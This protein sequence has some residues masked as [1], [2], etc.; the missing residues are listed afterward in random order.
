MKTLLLTLLLAV[1]I[2]ACND[3]ALPTLAPTDDALKTALRGVWLPTQ[4]QIKYQI[5]LTP[6]QRDTTVTL[7][8][9]TAP[10]LVPGRANV[11]MPFTDTLYIGTVATA[12]IDTFFTRNRGSRQQGNFFLVS[13]A[14][15]GATVL[16]IGRPTYTRG[17]LTRWNY[18]F[19][20]HGTVL[21]NAQNQP[22]FTYTSY[23]NY[24]L[25]VQSVSGN[26]LVL[27]FQTTGN[28]NNLPQVPITP[29]NQSLNTT[30]GGRVALITATF[31]K[32]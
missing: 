24:P 29:A 19:V 16:R 31:T 13:G 6:R 11:I 3:D 18:D 25:T 12:R 26:R 2:M 9:T 30:W 23:P 14:D 32:Q 20:F 27:G 22:T 7:T 10:L 17:Q 15:A 21:P 28:V 8:P 1:S 4:L 5:G